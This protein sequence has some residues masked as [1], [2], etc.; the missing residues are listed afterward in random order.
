MQGCLLHKQSAFP[1]YADMAFLVIRYARLCSAIIQSPL[2]FCSLTC[3]QKIFATAY[4][5]WRGTHSNKKLLT[6]CFV[7]HSPLFCHSATFLRLH[8][9]MLLGFLTFL[10]FSGLISLSSFTFF[11]FEDA[12]TEEQGGYNAWFD[13]YLPLSPYMWIHN[14]VSNRY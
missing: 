7:D 6:C 13:K 12:L 9:K 8:K 14:A 10:I 5:G 3:C 1:S 11:F 4:A 2:A